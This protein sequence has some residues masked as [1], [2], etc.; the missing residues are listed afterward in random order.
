[1]SASSL[2]VAD[3]V[4][5]QPVIGLIWAQSENGVI[6]QDGSIPW[7]VPE[8]LA[9]FK[10]TTSGHPVIMGRKTWDSF[11]DAFRPLPDRANIVISTSVTA[12][13]G[14]VV[15]PSLEAAF[16]EARASPGA[17][18]IWVIG[19]GRVYSDA[20]P[21]ANAA[22]VTVVESDAE[23]DTLAPVL[24]TEWQLTALTPDTGWLESRNG[25][26]YR[27]SLWTKQG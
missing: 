14:A 10:A 18:E 8:D 15:V 13:P 19:G 17:E 24:G 20:M 25:T 4:G 26:R 16:E 21:L 23:G 12:L 27:I 22:L 2:S 1:M 7:H 3:A 5:D 9:L 6:G 11:P